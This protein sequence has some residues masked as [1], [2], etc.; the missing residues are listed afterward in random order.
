LPILYGC[1]LDQDLAAKY[2]SVALIP[3]ILTLSI[4][5]L[6]YYEALLHPIENQLIRMKMISES[7]TELVGNINKEVRQP[8]RFQSGNGQVIVTSSFIIKISTYQIFICRQTEARLTTTSVNHIIVANERAN[9]RKLT[10]EQN[11]TIDV[12]AG[13]TKFQIFIKGSEFEEFAHVLSAPLQNVDNFEYTDLW[14]QFAN[15]SLKVVEQN[16]K[17]E[18]REI[19]L[20]DDFCFGCTVNQCEVRLTSCECR[21]MWCF[22]CLMRCFAAHQ[23]S[24]GVPTNRWLSGT[25]LCPNCRREFNI[26]QVAFLNDLQS[27]LS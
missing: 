10:T 14:T 17:V 22:N 12:T 11:L 19:D 18:R 5:A 13:D 7:F 2:W 25:C 9:N 16:E 6:Y 1:Y 24:T 23:S 27:D 3:F 20:R 8:T 26:L 4:L 21:S 15:E